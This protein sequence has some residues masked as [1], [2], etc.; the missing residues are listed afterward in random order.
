MAGLTNAESAATL[1]VRFPTTGGTD[2]I[3][4]SVNGSSEFAGLARTAIGATGWAAATV[5]DPSVKANAN[6][7]TSAAA[8]SG[9]TGRPLRDLHRRPRAAR[10]GPTGRRWRVEDGRHR[11]PAHL[12]H[13]RLHRHPD[14]SRGLRHRLRGWSGAITARRH[15]QRRR[16]GRAGVC[17][18]R[19]H[20]QPHRSGPAVPG[21]HR[22][23]GRPT[24]S[25]R[26]PATTATASTPG[27]FRTLR[28][29]AYLRWR[30]WRRST[31]WA[32][33]PAGTRPPLRPPRRRRQIGTCDVLGGR[34]GRDRRRPHP[35]RVDGITGEISTAYHHR[36][37]SGAVIYRAVAG[38]TP[39]RPR[40]DVHGQRDFFVRHGRR[41][42]QDV[43]DPLEREHSAHHHRRRRR[44]PSPLGGVHGSSMAT[45]PTARRR[46]P[47]V[48][49]SPSPPP[50]RY[51]VRRHRRPEPPG[52]LRWHRLESR[53]RCC[54]PGA[55]SAAASWTWTGWT[56]TATGAPTA[57]VALTGSTTTVGSVSSS[58]RGA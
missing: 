28:Q 53:L 11:R 40:A 19:V 52:P 51:G 46:P 27:G 18:D 21:R 17:R 38:G 36:H 34:C 4:Y 10:S 16:R 1:D 5:A 41:L 32:T 58:G 48:T 29:S 56:G 20:R 33:T 13:R 35:V 43:P 42:R 6:A 54:P 39:D 14:L 31:T 57:T 3:A 25:C 30:P 45:Q 55:D 8:S 23:G 9:G 7:L 37:D 50:R 2:H 49:P 24:R 22:R 47:V 44:R 15:R 26:R 12:G